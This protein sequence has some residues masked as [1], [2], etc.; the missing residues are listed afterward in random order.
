MAR[1]TCS[2]SLIIS[3]VISRQT[4]LI[5]ILGPRPRQTLDKLID[6]AAKKGQLTAL[7]RN[8]IERLYSVVSGEADGVASQR[9]A[10]TGA[11]IRSWLVSAQ[12]GSAPISSFNDV[13]TGAMARRANGMPLTR[14]IKNLFTG[15]SRGEAARM[16]IAADASLLQLQQS[17]FGDFAGAS[18]GSGRA[19]D[20]TLRASGLTSW[21]EA[22]RKAFGVEFLNF[23]GEHVNK[24]VPFAELPAPLQKQLPKYG[25]EPLHWDNLVL[26]AKTIDKNGAHFLDLDSF[27]SLVKDLGVSKPFRE[28]AEIA[29]AREAIEANVTTRQS[30]KAAAGRRMDAEHTRARRLYDEVQSIRDTEIHLREM[31]STE[32]EFAMIS[33]TDARVKALTTFGAERGSLLGEL[34]RTGFLY[35]SFPLSIM[36]THLAR[37]FH[38][39]TVA[40]ELAYLGPFVAASS[41][42]GALSI[43]AREMVKG[44]T[45]R[46]MSM[47][48]FWTDALQQ[49]G[50]LTVFEQALE[51]DRGFDRAATQA[52]GPGLGLARDVWNLTGKNAMRLAEDK[53]THV[54]RE[55][56]KFAER[57]TPGTNL[58][59][60]RLLA[61]RLVW[62]NLQR[63]LDDDAEGSFAKQA[64]APK[65]WGGEYWWAPGEI[66]P[67]EG[68]VYGDQLGY[69]RGAGR[70]RSL[71]YRGDVGGNGSA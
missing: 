7:Q 18:R 46:D 26:R 22:G 35:K 64:A 51:A 20:F 1:K 49:G 66:L 11:F 29:R 62:N 10:N 6:D 17:Q 41:I 57:Y 42:I 15:L 13:V 65:R 59:Q 52:G 27:G 68:G 30:G 45:P 40:G 4:A 2:T 61:Q 56:S 19:A 39:P 43:Q 36:F 31:L 32:S 16:G 48:S 55:A 28:A 5:E 44:R 24:K 9:L 54:G 23:L 37:G 38:Q 8:R 71:V 70:S 3:Y 14:G 21:T 53:S 33:G 69:P 47:P 58:W 12:L 25:I 60:T 34:G 63:V 50:A 67:V